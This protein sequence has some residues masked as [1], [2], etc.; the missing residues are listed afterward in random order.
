MTFARIVSRTLTILATVGI[1]RSATSKTMTVIRI[2]SRTPTIRVTVG[3][4]GVCDIKNDDSYENGAS[5]ASKTR[6]VT[7][8]LSW[9]L[10]ILVTVRTLERIG[11][12]VRGPYHDGV[13]GGQPGDWIMYRDY[14][15][16]QL[17]FL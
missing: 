12:G 1:V 2:V 7:R 16:P 13:G 4:F 9:T 8:I 11:L 17:R 6:T 15:D 3:T 5:E 14:R 10:T